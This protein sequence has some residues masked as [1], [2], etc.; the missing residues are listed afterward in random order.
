MKNKLMNLDIQMFAETADNDPIFDEMG[1]EVA[2]GEET[3]VSLVDDEPEFEDTADPTEEGNETI[4]QEETNDVTE[5]KAFSRRLKEETAKVRRE[6]QEQ[7]DNFAVS[8]GFK[9]WEELV[10]ANEQE[11]LENLG[12]NDTE[13]FDKFLEEKI[14]NNPTV[15]EAQKILEQQ[16]NAE[17]EKILNNEINLI[18]KMD[19]SIKSLDDLANIPEYDVL[20]DKA[21]N[22]GYSLSDA[23]KVVAFDRVV[24]SAVS[25]GK[26]AVISN[27]NSKSHIKTTTGAGADEII[28]PKEVLAT[29]KKNMPEM[30]EEE[31]KKNYAKFMKGGV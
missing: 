3:K 10:K 27:L 15:L 29:Y 9:D 2:D 25:N 6:S 5:T 21:I 20:M 16:K 8:C 4:I 23:F 31:I 24:E 18:S 19:P 12:I 7:M 17:I 11:K 30:T 22:R 13:A 1:A 28:V 26:S 14:K